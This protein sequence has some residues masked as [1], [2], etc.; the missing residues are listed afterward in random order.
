MRK[1]IYLICSQLSD[2]KEK[3]FFLVLELFIA[4]FAMNLV[5]ADFINVFDVTKLYHRL[6]LEKM[7]CFSTADDTVINNLK[8]D[9]H[10]LWSSKIC[11]SN[12]LDDSINGEN[13]KVDY[14]TNELVEGM[15]YSD[16]SGEWFQMNN[17]NTVQ[18]VVPKSLAEKY[19]LGKTYTINYLENKNKRLTFRVVGVLEN[20][21]MFFLPNDS[22]NSLI[23]KQQNC[24]MVYSKN[25]KD[26]YQANNK[27]VVM[28]KFQNDIAL[29]NWLIENKTNSSVS[30]I[31][32][33]DEIW[34]EQNKF[35]VGELIVPGLVG[36]V[37][38]ILCVVGLII[39]NLLTAKTKER[40]YGIFFLNG[41]TTKICFL[42]QLIS[43]ALPVVIALLLSQ[44][45]LHLTQ[46]R[47]NAKLYSSE[48]MIFSAVI[49]FVI[50]G[51]MAFI[52]VHE[53]SK[54]EPIN[55]IE[56]W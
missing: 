18:A 14:F 50:V 12:L 24:I 33:I 37:V 56:K 44:A 38:L 22:Y 35:Q 4:I 53:F 5:L 45:T 1:Y 49:C 28:V 10:V 23:D 17:T 29:E 55:I 9:R 31:A 51:I 36:S 16:L 21:N 42:I 2:N 19:Q 34:Q 20:D 30:N 52:N 48:G 8:S 27:F 3:K 6:D 41:A 43:E 46:R 7:I 13:I 15:K 26:Y 39:S 54:R 25:N 47:M 32:K 40:S 11:K